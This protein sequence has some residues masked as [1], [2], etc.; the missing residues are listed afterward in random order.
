M[1]DEV[2]VTQVTDEK[3]EIQYTPTAYQ[4]LADR[5]G[6]ALLAIAGEI[7]D[8]A[9]PHPTTRPFE[10][11]HRTVPDEFIAS[12]TH[13]VDET[14]E[15]GQIGVFDSA[16]AR[17]MLQFNEAFTAFA[18]QLEAV[19]NSLRFTMGMKK[20]VHASA[21]LQ[22]YAFLKAL[23]RRRPDIRIRVAQLARELHRK[24]KKKKSADE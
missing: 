5:L 4:L 15:V 9:G 23:G 22:A 24:G 7:P 3:E 8:L 18:N 21:A 6:A 11:A 14:E 12:M 20:A 19:L 1:S 13:V 2:I 16:G 10:M 17:E